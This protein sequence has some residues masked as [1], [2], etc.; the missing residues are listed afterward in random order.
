MTPNTPAYRNLECFVE[1]SHPLA[2]EARES[3]ANPSSPYG[4]HQ[5]GNT[6]IG[7][8]RGYK[9]RYALALMENLGY[10]NE[11]SDS[12]NGV[13]TNGVYTSLGVKVAEFHGPT[14][15]SVELKLIS[16]VYNNDTSDVANNIS[17]LFTQVG[18]I[19]QMQQ[20][21]IPVAY[22]K[23]EYNAAIERINEELKN[24]KKRVKKL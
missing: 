18:F 10:K 15:E 6:P 17:V 23:R 11:L 19:E 13:C 16:D 14:M 3:L 5:N 1:S 2:K 4:D 22:E 7:F 24:I 9:F 12:I 20:N 21:G 8:S